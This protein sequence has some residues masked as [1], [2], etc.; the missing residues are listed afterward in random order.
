MDRNSLK[1]R[2]FCIVLI[3][4]SLIAL[5]TACQDTKVTGE[6]NNPYS[7]TQVRH[8]MA[9]HGALVA[10]FDGN[11]WWFLSGDRWIKLENAGAYKFALLSPRHKISRF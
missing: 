7:L 2:K 10:K 11:Q 9:Y 8:M 6:Y 1:I 3:V 4:V 5:M